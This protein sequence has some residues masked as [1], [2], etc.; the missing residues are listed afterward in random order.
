MGFPIVA[1][2]GLGMVGAVGAKVGTQHVYPWLVEN[3]S[4]GKE[5]LNDWLDYTL[6]KVET[7]FDFEH[8]ELKGDIEEKNIE[9]N[10]NIIK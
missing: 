6:A 3:A 1:A 7:K 9:R 5:T 4:K 2:F 10:M 8:A